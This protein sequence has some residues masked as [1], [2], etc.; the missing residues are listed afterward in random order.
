MRN[1]TSDL[2]PNNFMAKMPSSAETTATVLYEANLREQ[3]HRRTLALV[4]RVESEF[5]ADVC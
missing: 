5:H 3:L 1:T 2:T 4:A